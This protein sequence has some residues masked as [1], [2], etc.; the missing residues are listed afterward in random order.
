MINSKYYREHPDQYEKNKK[1]NILNHQKPKWKKYNKEYLKKRR[2]ECK[3][4]GICIR[5]FKEKVYE[6]YCICKKCMKGGK[7][8]LKWKNVL[9]IGFNH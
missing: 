6:N 4:N 9:R 5:C 7:K 1:L 8:W 3:K 2:E